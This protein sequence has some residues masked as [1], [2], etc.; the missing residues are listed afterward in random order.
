MLALCRVAVTADW[1]LADVLD[2]GA[3]TFDRTASVSDAL[4]GPSVGAR[5]K[6][7]AAFFHAARLQVR[8][9]LGDFSIHRV[10]FHCAL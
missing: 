7:K 8:L 2:H 5:E 9:D 10:L 4:D 6:A 3:Q 1:I